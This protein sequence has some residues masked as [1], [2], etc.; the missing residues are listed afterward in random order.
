MASVP[1]DIAA[2]TSDMAEVKSD[3]QAIKAAVTDQSQDNVGVRSQ[4][5][6]QFKDHETRIAHLEERAA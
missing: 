4:Q 3:I 6:A 5:E 2:L 1:G